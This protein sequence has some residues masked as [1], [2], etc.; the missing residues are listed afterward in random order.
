MCITQARRA[1]LARCRGSQ[2]THWQQLDQG[3]AQS[4]PFC[5][6]DIINQTLPLTLRGAGSDS[7][8]AK[9]QFYLYQS[10]LFESR[11]WSIHFVYVFS[12]YPLN[13]SKWVSPFK[14]IS[15]TLANYSYQQQ[16]TPQITKFCQLSSQRAFVAKTP[17]E[18]GCAHWVDGSL[19][20]LIY[21]SS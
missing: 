3:R 19:I 17:H 10:N 12:L 2:N 5:L 6:W 21:N 7:R 15:S 20:F 9:I 18:M 4:H 11:L 14:I 13:A 16:C 8:G 1:V